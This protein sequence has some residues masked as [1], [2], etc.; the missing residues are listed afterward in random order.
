MTAAVAASGQGQAAVTVEII[1]ENPMKIEPN[2]PAI[3][4]AAAPAAPTPAPVPVLA[5]LKDIVGADRAIELV[6]AT[7]DAKDLGAFVAPIAA[8]LKAARADVTAKAAQIA[9]LTAKLA[10]ASAAPAVVTIA[11]DGAGPAKTGTDL[12][13]KYEASAELQGQFGSFEA[14]Q[15]HIEFEA[16]K[17]A[18]A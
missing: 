7:P 3:V 18:K 17:Q 6:T 4:P 10:A 13:A 1:G 12:K 15:E 9:D 5:Q 8:D 2:A 14:Y 11:A 16:K